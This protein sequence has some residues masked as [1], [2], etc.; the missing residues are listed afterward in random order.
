LGIAKA[1]VDAFLFES[2][3]TGSFSLFD[4]SEKVFKGE[5]DIFKSLLEDLTV[6][7]FEPGEFFF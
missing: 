1:I 2:G 5:I 7:F 6:D 4:V 3:I